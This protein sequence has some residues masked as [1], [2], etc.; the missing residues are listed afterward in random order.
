VIKSTRMR[1]AGNV[2]RMGKE[3]GC[4]GS[5]WGNRWEGDQWGDLG[6][7]EYIIL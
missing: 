1:W 7:D 6:V 3:R 5:C 2:A 4:I